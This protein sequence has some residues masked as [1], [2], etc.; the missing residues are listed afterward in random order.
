MAITDKSEGWDGIPG[1]LAVTVASFAYVGLDDGAHGLELDG[2][3]ESE[4]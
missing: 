2:V 4:W 1:L 3:G